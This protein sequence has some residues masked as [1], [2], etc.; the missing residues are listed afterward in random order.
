M[1]SFD[2]GQAVQSQPLKMTSSLDQRFRAS[3]SSRC[4]PEDCMQSLEGIMNA[5]NPN[6]GTK[7]IFAFALLRNDSVCHF[8][9]THYY[10]GRTLEPDAVLKNTIL[11]HLD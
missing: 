3:E 6:A 1:L 2:D 7:S 5:P 8:L 9:I 10:F 11:S 4:A